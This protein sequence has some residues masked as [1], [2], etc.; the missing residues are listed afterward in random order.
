MISL[1]DGY[2]RTAGW[3]L[4]KKSRTA[5]RKEP[6]NTS[7]KVSFIFMDWRT[8]DLLAVKIGA[9]IWA[10][11]RITHPGYMIASYLSPMPPSCP[12]WNT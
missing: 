12:A 3:C 9:D 6:P 11:Q 7:T 8:G 5:S 10:T 4:P 2:K 1:I